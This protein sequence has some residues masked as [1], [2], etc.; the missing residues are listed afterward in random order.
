MTMVKNILLSLFML[1]SMSMV[2]QSDTTITIRVSSRQPFPQIGLDLKN[3]KYFVMSTRQDKA[4]LIALEKGLY[5]DSL[6]TEFDK[7]KKTCDDEILRLNQRVEDKEDM[8]DLQN[9][10]YRLLE[11]N[12]KGRGTEL[13][14]MKIS[15]EALK[16]QVGRQKL[17]MWFGYAAGIIG[18]IIIIDNITY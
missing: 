12:Y 4:A 17:P 5:A 8:I 2:G 16:D 3:R 1:L 11:E 15:N 6:L 13:D 9:A 18:G 14:N 7:Y 10:S